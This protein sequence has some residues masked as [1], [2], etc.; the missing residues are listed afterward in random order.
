M[1]AAGA[2]ALLATALLGTGCASLPDSAFPDADFEGRVE[3]RETPFFPQERY[4][5]GPAALATLLT[6]T[7][8]ETSPEALVSRVYIPARE[9]S[10]QIE[11]VA[12]TR[13][14]GRIAYPIGPSLADVIAELRAGRPVLVLQNLGVAWI[15]RWHYAVIV[16]FD[17]G[18]DE[19]ILR[20]GTDQRRVTRTATFL[21]TWQRSGFWGFVALT[22][23]ELPVD[24]DRARYFVAAADYESTSPAGDAAKAWLAAVEHWPADV[25]PP[26]ALGNLALGETRNDAAIRW[27]DEALSREPTHVMTRN[28][29]AF[30]LADVGRLDEALELLREARRDASGDA[31]AIVNDSIAELEAR[32]GG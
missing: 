31:L 32:S 6:R 16:G 25:I 21:R 8:V 29:K 19:V 22:P 14:L 2:I 18:T 30:A 11:M 27:Y 10:L 5:C 1:R 17:A 24:P 9:G 26:F 7:G 23:G 20:S 12:T 4:Q 3:L 13:A 28:N 15:P